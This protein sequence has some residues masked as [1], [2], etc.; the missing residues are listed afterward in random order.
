VLN[1]TTLISQIA[2]IIVAARVVGIL[3]RRIRQPQVMGEMVAGILLGPSLLGWVAP[4]AAATLFP[5][6]SLVYLNALSQVGLIIFMFLVGL[7]LNPTELSRHKHSAVLVSHVSIV[8]PF[9][10]ATL[11]ALYFYPRLSDQ[12]VTFTSFALFM[13]AAMSI[14]AFPVLARILTEGN[15]RHTTLG[16][17]A[18]ACAAVDDVSGWC[19]LAYIV[20]VV[21]A[22][23]SSH[24]LWFTLTGSVLFG[25][26]MIYGVRRLLRGFEMAFRKRRTLSENLIALIVLLAFISA[27]MTEWLGVHVLFGSFLLGAIMP[28]DRAFVRYLT[29]KLE[30][31]PVV[32]LLPVFFAL[33]GL[34][35]RIT[36]F[37]GAVMWW[38][39][40]LIILVA[41]TGKLGGSM[42]AARVT[43]M[44]WREAAGLGVL[45]NTRGLMEL[46]IL[47]I[48]FDIKVISPAVF[49][50]MVLMALVTTF[51]TTPL[52]AWIYPAGFR[53][54]DLNAEGS[55]VADFAVLG[56]EWGDGPVG[57][58]LKR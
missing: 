35:T 15:M 38:Y 29:S 7:D 46:V 39:C 48:G 34:R 58:V 45:M 5:P 41:I 30:S 17:V 21:R 8:A 10:L 37:N 53:A 22:H 25:L 56:A 43:G 18:L 14:T 16:T 23:Q 40:A 33:T 1:L 31:I 44:P 13:G 54:Q 32:L 12:S 2:V 47:N 28:K 50:M 9:F 27:F 19:V 3:F 20:I 24:P 51:M 42:M 6:S 4:G 11:L 57:N 49:S 36:L 26:I 52:L 55:T